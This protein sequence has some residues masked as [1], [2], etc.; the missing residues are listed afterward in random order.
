MSRDADT[1]SNRAIHVALSSVE[2]SLLGLVAFDPDALP[3]IRAG[4]R[5]NTIDADDSGD[6]RHAVPL[7]A[8][9]ATLWQALAGV[10][11]GATGC[12]QP[13]DPAMLYRPRLLPDPADRSLLVSLTPREL[14]EGLRASFPDAF[15]RRDKVA[16]RI[17]HLEALEWSHDPI[18]L[19]AAD[20]LSDAGWQA[21]AAVLPDPDDRWHWSPALRIAARATRDD[22]GARRRRAAMALRELHAALHLACELSLPGYDDEGYRRDLIDI[23]VADPTA[24]AMLREAD[25]DPAD[26]LEIVRLALGEAGQ[27]WRASRSP[28]VA[29]TVPSPAARP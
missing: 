25:D 9:P 29:S 28:M 21:V 6:L 22:A 1:G 15:A 19:V 4:Q 17:V 20:A 27:A 23:V 26:D 14:G 10:I 12:M 8:W 24:L 11:V 13:G 3:A 7:D 16:T 18:A 5:I 2:L